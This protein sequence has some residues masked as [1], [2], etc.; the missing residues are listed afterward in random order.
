ML[1]QPVA[2]KVLLFINVSTSLGITTSF[3]C[4]R[5]LLADGCASQKASGSLMGGEQLRNTLFT[6]CGREIP[7]PPCQGS[8]ADASLAHPSRI[9]H[10]PLTSTGV[11]LR[12]LVNLALW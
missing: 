12:G 7:R 2:F 11:A 4:C 1:Y 6:H 8:R 5:A 3:P 9:F 10:R